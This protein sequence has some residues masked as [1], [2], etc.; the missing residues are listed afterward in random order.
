MSFLD[1]FD[2]KKPI[3]GMIHLTGGTG[4]KI[5]ERAVWEIGQL[6]DAGVDAVLVEDYYGPVKEVEWTLRYLQENLPHRVYGVNILQNFTGSY[7]MAKKYGAAFMQIDSICRHLPPKQDAQY[8]KLIGSIRD[9]SVYVLGGVRF[10]YQP[11]LSGRSVEED[12]RLGMERCD[13]IVVTGEGTGL[14]TDIEKIKSF[15][16]VTGSFPP[17]RGRGDDRR[18]GQRAAYIL[19]RGH[20]GQL[21]QGGRQRRQPGGSGQSAPLHGRGAGP[22]GWPVTGV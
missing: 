21:V 2:V 17:D 20:R 14:N 5:R 16:A 19:R 8:E 4:E 12:L 11:V 13:G 6:Y 15:R 7:E 1:L 18:D 10:K 9:G 22:S 3:I